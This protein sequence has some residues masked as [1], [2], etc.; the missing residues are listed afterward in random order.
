MNN[1]LNNKKVA[2]IG[3]PNVGKS[4]IFNY[5]TNLKQHTGNW[6][7]KTVESATGY[8]KYN[9]KIYTLVD[10]P[11]TYSLFSSSKEEEVSRD[12]ICF[13]NYDLV[14]IIIDITM[15]QRNLNL[16][17]QILETNNNV[18]ICANLMDEALNLGIK[19]NLNK[20][21]KIL[22]VPVI[23]TS[24]KDKRSLKNLIKQIDK[25]IDNKAFNNYLIKY[26]KIIE[27]VIYKINKTLDKYTNNINNRF[28]SIRLINNDK[29]YNN[30]IYNY[31]KI[32]KK[33]RK[34]ID[35]I[36]NICNNYLI[37]NKI[38]DYQE[39][40]TKQIVYN[41][42]EIYNNVIKKEKER[43][44]K[45]DKILSS[46]LFGMPIMLLFFIFILWLTIKG[47]NYPSKILSDILFSINN[48]L[49]KF[50][51][52]IKMP[53]IIIEILINGVLKTLSWVISVM[54]PPMAIF[55]PLF[56]LL[57]EIGFL[58]RIAF[59]L[60]KLFNKANCHG[61]QSLT[62]CM[63]LGCNS[64]GVTGC[65][66]IESK[67]DR[68]IA[69]LTNS[70]I[71]CNGRFPSLIAII[72][73][74]LA[75]GYFSSLKASIILMF[76]III[77]IFITLII[78]KL[79]SKIIYKNEESTF[80][81]EIPP[82]RKPNIKKVIVRSIFDKTLHV[83]TRAISIAAPFGLIIWLCANIKVGNIS[84]LKHC[85]NILDPIGNIFGV[86]GTILMA[87]ILGFPANEIVIPIIIMSYMN[88]S[89][90]TDYNN[91]LELKNLLINNG[92][93]TI[94]S[95]CSLFLILFHFPCSTTILTIKK[96]TN[97]K[98][99]TFIAFLLPTITGLLICFIINTLYN[100]F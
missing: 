23:P 53:N 64:C 52:Y 80:I 93:N 66:I 61:K 25:N 46:K 42:D 50:L 87:L 5:L 59:N 89:S 1:N 62:M 76:I 57:E 24:I 2:F 70:F 72:T 73:M 88:T 35:N 8:Y 21:S 74:F 94:T 55:F 14:V 51:L 3:N 27:D 41:S 97:S 43:N 99:L 47:A 86:D 65:R 28:F 31:L 9:D 6:T 85:T 39:E 4:S 79:L 40:I 37:S 17:L 91:L 7:G 67:K 95:I 36:I 12:F 90:L 33:D 30:K 82:F 29:D 54:L 60:D 32:N 44:I 49:Y 13:N 81:L 10:L 68:I 19:P 75:T 16:V 96:E 22:K 45:L 11:G 26:N 69:I 84:I 15:L 83:L 63:G 92:W 77:A 100:L 58:P 78:S 48:Y 56:T 20:L 38:Y 98:I 34:K 18:I 71:P